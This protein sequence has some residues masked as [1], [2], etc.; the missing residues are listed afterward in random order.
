[1]SSFRLDRA[2]RMILGAIGNRGGAF[3]AAHT[4]WARRKLARLFPDLAGLGFGHH[5]AGRIAMTSDHVP[6]VLDFGPGALAVFGYS[7]RGIGPGTVFGTAAARALLSGDRAAL[8]I[9]PVRGHAERLPG[10]QALWY[11]G[12]AALSHA[13]ACR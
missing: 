10:V 2:G 8:P 3:G 13:L 4:A 1:M 9:A 7:G 5:W 12:G 11:E 6:K